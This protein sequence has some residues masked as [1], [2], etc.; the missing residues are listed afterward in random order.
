MLYRIIFMLLS[1]FYVFPPLN[2]CNKL[3]PKYYTD[4]SHL[5]PRQ[6][7][8]A[9]MPVRLKVWYWTR[10]ERQCIGCLGNGTKASTVV[11]PPRPPVSGEQVSTLV[12][13]PWAENGGMARGTADGR[14]S[15]PIRVC[16][17]L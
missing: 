7:T 6:N 8:G 1:L 9:L 16:R 2:I 14:A 12:N 3:T 5:N 15:V 13:Q 10:M 17:L 11:A 4:N